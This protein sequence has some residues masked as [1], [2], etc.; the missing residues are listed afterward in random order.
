MADRRNRSGRPR[1][2]ASTR[3]RERT[4]I[5]SVLPRADTAAPATDRRLRPGGVLT[6]VDIGG[7]LDPHPELHDLAPLLLLPLR[8]EYRIVQAMLRPRVVDFVP[9]DTG[10]RALIRGVLRAP[11]R[12]SP[13]PIAGQT[14]IWFRWYPDD[15][16]STRGIAPIT[17]S[18]NKLLAAFRTRIAARSPFDLADPE[19]LAAW[20]DFAGQVGA[21][22]ALHLI[23]QSSQPAEAFDPASMGGIIAL[24]KAVSL[25]T[26]TAEQIELLGTGAPIPPNAPGQRSV[27]SYTP[28]AAEPGGWLREFPI[29]EKNGMAL[30]IKGGALVQRA[31]GADYIIAVGQSD[32]DGA[33]E[34]G[35][36]IRDGIANGNFELLRQDTPTNNSPAARTSTTEPL[37][38]LTS[39]VGN[40]AMDERS[41]VPDNG[42]AAADLLADA[43]GIDR[44]VVRKA[45]QAGDTPFADARAMLRVIGPA[46]LDGGLDGLTV[47]KDVDENT[48]I[49]ILAAAFCARGQ[50][51]PVRFGQNAYGV[52]PI[53]TI[54][55]VETANPDAKIAGV[56]DFLATYARFVRAFLPPIAAGAVPV[57]EPNDPSAAAKIE[58]LLKNNRVSTR[59]VVAEDTDPNT[60]PVGCP[61]V[62]GPRPQDQPASYLH[63]LASTALAALP[64]PADDDTSTPLLYRLARLALTVNVVNIVLGDMTSTPGIAMRPAGP[65]IRPSDVVFADPVVRG[66]LDTTGWLQ[67]SVREMSTL[68][69]SPGISRFGIRL[70]TT[71]VQRFAD[72]LLQLERIAARPQG[73]AELEM[74]LFETIDLFQHRTDAWVTGLAYARLAKLRKNGVHGLAAGYYGFIGK[75]R[76]A[77]ATGRSNGYI[78]APSMA[79]ATT[80][81]ILRSAHLRQAGGGAFSIDLASR[82]ARQA[83]GFLDVLKKGIAIEEALG[84]RGERW[85]HDHKLSRLTLDLR[86]QFPVMNAVG[87]ED[88][89]GT[90][91]PG[92]AGVRVFDGVRFIASDL[93]QFPA[94]DQQRLQALKA[95]LA[96]D[97][98][99]LSDLVMAEAAHQR[100]MGQAEASKAWLNVLSGGTIPG[101]PQFIRTQRSAQGSTYRLSF[102]LPKSSPPA[103]ATPREI[104]EPALAALAASYLTQFANASVRVT[105]ERTNDPA[106]RHSLDV[107]LQADLGM[108]ALDLVL[109]GRSEFDVRLRHHVVSLWLHD[110]AFRVALGP[111]AAEGLTP[112]VNA[113][114]RI[115]V[116]GLPRRSSF[117][118]MVAKAQALRDMVQGA[119]MLEPA[120]LNAAASPAS[121]LAETAEVMLLNGGAAQLRDRAGALA[122]AAGNALTALSA[123]RAAFLQAIRPIRLA[124]DAGVTPPASLAQLSVAEA[125]RRNLQNARVAIAAYCEPAALRAF[126]L[127]EAIA[128]PDALEQLMMAIE[129]RMAAKLGRL[130]DVI[131]ATSSDVTT[132]LED[133]R[134]RRRALVQVLQSTLD[135]DALPILVPFAKTAPT[136]PMVD[137]AQ[138]IDTLVAPW[139]RVRSRVARSADL[140][141]GITGLKAFPVSAAA[142]GAIPSTDPNRDPRDETE[143]PLSRHFGILLA[144]SS[145]ITG[146]VYAGFVTD[147]WAEQRPSRTQSG[148][149]ALNYDSPQAEAP[150]CLLLCVGPR[151]TAAATWADDTAA[152]MVAE[153]IAWM[154][155]R[156]MSTDD[157][158]WPASFLPNASQV[159]FKGTTA[160]IPKRTFRGLPTDIG[161]IDGVFAVMANIGPDQRWGAPKGELNERGGFYGIEE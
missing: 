62:I 103:G 153:A 4:T 114:A 21:Y 101:T 32:R 52:L 82:R 75:L 93:S 28:I 140:A 117:D 94:A 13:V 53:T 129:A 96:E 81:A 16:L 136:T 5:S 63:A 147:E 80:A 35:A 8:L 88:I 158:P 59:L 25:F 130:Q 64:D 71:V 72:A 69:S 51:P 154:K 73:T 108:H 87:P 38:D 6:D 29:A 89:D 135:G 86:R 152:R 118:Q 33:A 85:L 151:R 159:P 60:A 30:R 91:R 23:R 104:A 125:A 95:T 133:A 67:R 1:G 92:D 37:R 36:L 98:D 99:A 58:E 74:L 18:E 146:N 54:A 50:L 12:S 131:A 65:R 157:K 155:I 83:L 17:E 9:V 126:T 47:V 102:V 45:V 111:V 2:T 49:D 10:S 55:D 90:T 26:I 120:D 141:K 134:A 15:G 76:E 106:K 112:F 119:R 149:L 143:A 79:Q 160:R 107:R 144:K 11:L 3:G 109:G 128:D 105:I 43:L 138:P 68:R 7:V 139:R 40:A 115:G 116:S 20:T 142:T 123:A 145:T 31:L 61:Y 84:L 19:T 24:P 42:D 44:A 124:L 46:L 66:K 39:F 121:P 34:I 110:P 127:E 57:L 70:L 132:S 77:A 137:P 48:F 97:L 150:Q 41:A 56:H 22:R 27:I 161:S 100:S 148:G 14:E 113:E 122:T 156:A 78:Q